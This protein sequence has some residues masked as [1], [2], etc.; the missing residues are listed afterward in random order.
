MPFEPISA[1]ISSAH[2]PRH[3]HSV[4]PRVWRGVLLSLWAL[5]VIPAFAHASDDRWYRP[6]TES[7]SADRVFERLVDIESRHIAC[8]AQVTKNNRAETLADRRKMLVD[9][10]ACIAGP[11]RDTCRAP[12][13]A[14]E[15]AQLF[16]DQYYMIT[17]ASDLTLLERWQKKCNRIE[18]VSAS[19]LQDLDPRALCSS[20]YLIIPIWYEKYISVQPPGWGIAYIDRRRDCGPLTSIFWPYYSR[21]CSNIWK[22]GPRF[23]GP[24]KGD[25]ES[26]FI[27]EYYDQVD[28]DVCRILATGSTTLLT[29][30]YLESR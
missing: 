26:A 13:I 22:A 5:S 18:Q 2:T 15:T 21:R 3:F 9:F 7:M 20:S 29:E 6:A 24:I 1:A 4:G 17:K 28:W 27:Q 8:R 11:P 23:S 10:G 25:R 12:I 19:N 16:F 30:H 14:A